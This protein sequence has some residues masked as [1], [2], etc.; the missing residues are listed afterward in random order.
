[1]I[2][3]EDTEQLAV[4][5]WCEGYALADARARLLLHVPNGGSR[6]IAEASKLRRL[7]V[8]AGVPDL[9]LPVAVAPYHGLWIEM[10]RRK[11]G[12]VS[13]AQHGW[14]DALRA[15]GYAVSVSRGADEAIDTIIAYLG[16]TYA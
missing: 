12:L 4:I 15:E 7:G 11:G 3:T 8:R 16:G 9:L 14:I 6:H 13:A 10:K 2:P 1:M 5:A